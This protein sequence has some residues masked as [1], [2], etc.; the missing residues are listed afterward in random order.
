MKGQWTVPGSPV[1]SSHLIALVLNEHAG[2]LALKMRCGLVRGPVSGVQGT[3]EV[4]ATGKTCESCL[5]LSN[6]DS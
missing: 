5:R 4:P 3:D 2:M 1:P 6:R